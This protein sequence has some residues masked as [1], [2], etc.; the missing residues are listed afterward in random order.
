MCTCPMHRIF[1]DY[2]VARKVDTSRKSGCTANN[3]DISVEIRLLNE[4]S[5]GKL[6]SCM[7]KSYGGR[8]ALLVVLHLVWLKRVPLMITHF[9][10]LC[11]KHLRRGEADSSIDQ[12]LLI[13][14]TT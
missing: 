5:I 9:E 6:D 14:P 11:W 7:M 2:Q 3:I 8:N 10:D 13:P 4:L 12:L 1:Y